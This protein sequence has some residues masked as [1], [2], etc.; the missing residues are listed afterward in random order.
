MSVLTT[1]ILLESI[2]RD[3]V[4]TWLSEP[5]HHAKLLE[6][7]FDGFS[8]AGPREY[9]VTLKTPPRSAR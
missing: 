7:A 1:D 4:L 5:A 8:S 3:D 2:R 6:G 9:T